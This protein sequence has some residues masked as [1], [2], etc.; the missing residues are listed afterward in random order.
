MQPVQ[1]LSV[2]TVS[3]THSTER[4]CWHCR[5]PF[6]SGRKLKATTLYHRDCAVKLRRARVR[7][8]KQR[9]VEAVGWQQFLA[10]YAPCQQQRRAYM[11]DYMRER[12]LKLKADAA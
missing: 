9:Q 1:S 8:W 7:D 5:R 2:T 4:V 6:E 10:D 3:A 11:R 12:R